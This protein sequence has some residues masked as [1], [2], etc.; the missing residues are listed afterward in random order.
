[1][2]NSIQST[3]GTIRS[4]EIWA[5]VNERGPARSLDNAH[6]FSYFREKHNTA[7]ELT[8]GFL[9][10]IFQVLLQTEVVL[11]VNVNGWVKYSGTWYYHMKAA[12]TYG[13]LGP[14]RCKF[15]HVV[16]VQQR[17]HRSAHGVYPQ[18]SHKFSFMFSW[19][20]WT[21][22]LFPRNN[23]I[24]TYILMINNQ[25]RIWLDSDLHP[26]DLDIPVSLSGGCEP[27]LNEIERKVV[28]P[29]LRDVTSVRVIRR[30]ELYF[31][32]LRAAKTEVY[33]YTLTSFADHYIRG[34]DIVLQRMSDKTKAW[35]STYVH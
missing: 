8:F 26:I 14:G 3:N 27:L 9:G 19:T 31:I 7:S 18:R 6:G 21:R 10:L 22:S 16:V 28:V 11:R 5:S 35:W 33:K 24:A 20:G 34:W 30:V 12:D 29:Y 15:V 13:P 4:V 23:H 1:M 25:S 2:R 32:T 17:L